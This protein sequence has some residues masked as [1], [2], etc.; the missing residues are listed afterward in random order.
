MLVTAVVSNHGR[1]HLAST[2]LGK[3]PSYHLPVTNDSKT[4]Q[5]AR[6]WKVVQETK[7]I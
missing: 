4:E 3:L 1:E 6:I 2:H 5:E 7:R